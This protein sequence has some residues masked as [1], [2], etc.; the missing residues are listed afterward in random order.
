MA[1]AVNGTGTTLYSGKQIRISNRKPNILR[2]IWHG[3]NLSNGRLRMALIRFSLATEFVNAPAQRRRA[4][5]GTNARKHSNPIAQASALRVA[6]SRSCISFC[7][8]FDERAVP[9]HPGASL[10]RCRAEPR[11]IRRPCASQSPWPGS[12]R[13]AAGAADPPAGTLCCPTWA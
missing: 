8:E 11:R 7:V 10:G 13:W 3:A 6:V 5:A 9:R 4:C 1:P 12:S 2:R